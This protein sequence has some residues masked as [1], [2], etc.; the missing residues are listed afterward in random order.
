MIRLGKFYIKVKNNI[1]FLNNYKKYLYELQC[2]SNNIIIPD[3]DI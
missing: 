2:K 3:C 1:T